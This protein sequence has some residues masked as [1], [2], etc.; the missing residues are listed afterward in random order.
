MFEKT[1]NPQRHQPEAQA[2]ESADEVLPWSCANPAAAL[3]FAR[4]SGWCQLM[5]AAVF[6][7]LLLS[8][9]PALARSGGVVRLPN[10]GVKMKNGLNMEI[11]SRG[12]EATGYRPIRIK[13]S[14]FPPIAVKYDRQVRVTMQMLHGGGV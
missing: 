5:A 10:P 14:N 2:K 6:V 13:L 12:A 1:M 11:D 9:I 8:N 3:S 7:A 4:A